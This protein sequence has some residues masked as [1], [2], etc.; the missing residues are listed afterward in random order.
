MYH[1]VPIF[2]PFLRKKAV[3]SGGQKN[4]TST[5]V[6][7]QEVLSLTQAEPL[8]HPGGESDDVLDGTADL[9]A[10]NILGREATEGRRRENLQS[11]RFGVSI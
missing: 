10:D 9:H 1:L 6:R 4:D 2:R 5:P 8:A 3:Y 7:Q 11:E